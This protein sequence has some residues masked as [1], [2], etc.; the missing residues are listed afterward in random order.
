MGMEDHL[1]QRLVQNIKLFRVLNEVPAQ[2]V[3]N[4]PPVVEE[5][6]RTLPLRREIEI[7][8]NLAFLSA[9]TDDKNRVMGVCIEED[10]KNETLTIRLASNSG[11][12][13]DLEKGFNELARTLEICALRKSKSSVNVDAIYQIVVAFDRQR[14]LSRLRSR[15]AKNS[16][17]SRGKRPLMELLSETIHSP[18]LEPKKSISSSQLNELRRKISVMDRMFADF[19]ASGDATI[20]MNLLRCIHDHDLEK[21]LSAVCKA[22]L[23]GR[24]NDTTLEFLPKG[25]GK[26]SQYYSICRELVSAARKYPIFKR[27]FVEVCVPYSNKSPLSSV[28]EITLKESLTNL[29][30]GRN[31]KKINTLIS[32]LA[33]M[34]GKKNSD[35]G[36]EFENRLALLRN[37][38]KVHAE[39]Q[40]LLFYELQPDHRR[41][42]VIASSKSACYLC[43]IFIQTHG[44]YH[45]ARSHGR[46]YDGWMLPTWTMGASSSIAQVAQRFNSNL[47][48]EIRA[49]INDKRRPFVHPNE[50]VLFSHAAWTPSVSTVSNPSTTVTARKP[51][52]EL[53]PNEQHQ[54][55]QSE[56]IL[57]S[58]SPESNPSPGSLTP[59]DTEISAI[60]TETT[61]LTTK[62]ISKYAI[63][64]PTDSSIT[65]S[66][67]TTPPSSH[68]P[69]SY[70]PLPRGTV[71]Y[72]TLTPSQ[73]V[74][75]ISTRSLHLTIGQDVECSYTRRIGIKW[76]GSDEQ[77]KVN[78]DEVNMVDSA[79]LSVRRMMDLEVS[80]GGCDKAV[81]GK[82]EGFYV[83]VKKDLVWIGFDNGMV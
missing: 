76:L 52:S 19:E 71:I 66:N 5:G 30:P 13:G 37:G 4:D 33:A 3:T 56:V 21:Y 73:N 72:K 47:E 12:L 55:Q 6:D 78:L 62:I 46:L 45:M 40:L 61:P 39:I 50:S 23:K 25:I 36:E 14:I 35:L 27:I 82:G 11:P 20:L 17:K 43:T 59:K 80:G 18:L 29:Y 22:N 75:K 77:A 69:L 2:P 31:Q 49:I 10:T 7:A 68:P 74:W 1:Q 15:H 60:E 38:C 53:F 34:L 67:S 64:P 57:N 42:R 16:I 9:Y 70:E 54:H 26:I 8:D 63:A 65:G 79:S 28:P 24:L 48:D 32:Q 44:A 51:T 83:R 58:I 81:G 41:P